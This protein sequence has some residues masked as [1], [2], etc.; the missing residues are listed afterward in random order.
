MEPPRR[1]SGGRAG[2]RAKHAAGDAERSEGANA[3]RSTSEDD[4]AAISPPSGMET[5]RAATARYRG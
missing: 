4:G 1:L 2:S 5:N 3:A